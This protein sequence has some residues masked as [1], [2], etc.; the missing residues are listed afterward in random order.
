MATRVSL[1]SVPWPARPMTPDEQ[2]RLVSRAQLLGLDRPETLGEMP[3]SPGSLMGVA[4]RVPDWLR[5]IKQ[6]MTPQTGASTA[7]TGKVLQQTVLSD[8][9]SRVSR[10][11]FF[12]DPLQSLADTSR[13]LKELGRPKGVD[14]LPG[15]VNDPRWADSTAG[16]FEDA[17]DDAERQGLQQIGEWVADI[18]RQTVQHV[19][20]EGGS[21]VISDILEGKD[22]WIF[23]NVPGPGDFGWSGHENIQEIKRASDTAERIGAVVSD[24]SGIRGDIE[25]IGRIW[26][27]QAI[28]EAAEA[29]GQSYDEAKA[30]VRRLAQE[31]GPV[32][33]GSEGIRRRFGRRRRP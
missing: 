16:E 18:P 17:I 8:K 1:G 3:L 12:T 6:M 14:D 19:S 27:D 20:P 32:A 15:G 4:R 9:P 5:R 21:S 26:T 11:G 10:R 13:S 2:G 22:A 24:R 33:R 29:T 28:K 7:R 30:E 23:R 25:S 31:P